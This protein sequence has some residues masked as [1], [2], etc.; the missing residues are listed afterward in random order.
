MGRVEEEKE[1]EDMGE[2]LTED[3]TGTLL[4]GLPERADSVCFEVTLLVGLVLASE[5]VSVELVVVVADPRA[6]LVRLCVYSVVA[7]IEVLPNDA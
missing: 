1:K 6:V 4:L 3:M 7:C 5:R 2:D